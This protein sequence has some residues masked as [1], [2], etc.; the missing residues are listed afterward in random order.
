MCAVIEALKP[1]LIGADPTQ[2]DVLFDHL[3]QAALFYG[4]RGLGLFALS[5]IDIALWDI[6]GKVKNQPLYRLLGGTEARRLPTYVSLLRYHT[7]P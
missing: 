4:R 2:P 7:P 1:L 3:S 5:G 6:I